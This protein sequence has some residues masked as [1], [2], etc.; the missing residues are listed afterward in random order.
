MNSIIKRLGYSDRYDRADKRYAL[1]FPDE[2]HFIQSAE[3]NEIQSVQD[4]KLKRVAGYILQDGRKVSGGDPIVEAVTG[5]VTKFRLRLPVASIYI[6]GLV[7]DVPE[8]NYVLPASGDVSVGVRITETMQDSVSNPELRAQLVKFQE[9]YWEPGA[10]RVRFDVAWGHSLDEVAGPLLPVYSIRNGAI[11]TN[12]TNIDYS[13]IYN[14]I[15]DYSRESNG[16]FVNSGCTVSALGL[17]AA[18]EQQ[19]TIS[20]GVAYVNGRRIPRNQNFR[21][22]VKEEPDLRAISAEPHPFTQP[23]GG[24]QTFTLAKSP[25][26]EVTRV[27][28]EKEVTETVIHGPFTGAADALVHP[29]VTA[30]LEVKKDATVYTSPASWLLSQGKL[31]WSPGGPEPAPGTTYTVKYRYNDNVTPDLVTRDTVTVTGAANG[32]NVQFDYTYKMPRIDIIAMDMTGNV[33]YVPGVAAIDRPQAPKASLGQLELARVYNKWGVAPDIVESAVR[34]IEYAEIT[35]MRGA[36]LDLYDLVAQERLKADISSRDVAAKRGVFVDPFIDDDL[37]DQGIAQTAASFGGALRLPI[38]ARVHEFPAMT[39]V[40][41]LEF[42]DEVVL[43]QFRETGE[44]KIN[45]YATFTPMPGRAS[46]EPSVD[47]WTEKETLFP[48]N[49]TAQFQPPARGPNGNNTTITS[50]S[51]DAKVEKIRETTRAAEFVRQRDVNFRLEGFIEAETLTKVLFDGVAATVTG[52]GPANSDG[53]ITGVL[54]IPAS[55]PQGS[56]RVAFVGSVGTEASSTYVAN[57]SITTE[58]YRLATAL[59]GTTEELPDPVINVTN[60]TNNTNITVVNQSTVVNNVTNIN[61]VANTTI[62]NSGSR[63]NGSAGGR[64]DPLAQTFMLTEGRCI[65]AVRLKCKTKGASSNAIFVQIRTVE[66][67]LPTRTILAEAFVPGSDLAVG[68]WFT[69]RLSVPVYLEPGREYAFVAL[70]DDNTHSLAIAELGKIDQQNSIVSEQ[71]FVVGV[72]LSSSNSLTWTVHNDADLAFQVIACRFNPTE[73]TIPIGTFTA[74][75]MSDIIVN[76]GVETPESQASVEIILR[77]LNKPDIVASPG[78]RIQ[79]TEYI[80]NEAVQVLALLKGTSRLTPFLFPGLQV[81]EGEIKTT[82]DYVS[83]AMQA[84]DADRVTTTI[85]VFVPSGASLVVEIG[86]PGDWVASAPIK[87]TP[88]GDGVFE[89]TYQRKPYAPLDARTRI[90]LNGGPAARLEIAKLRTISTDI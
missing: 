33:L 83:R 36:L 35:N 63:G 22:T 75:K 40:Q 1:A 71:P 76:A 27:I 34:N 84:D 60:V 89:Q 86:V 50:V 67:G 43:S 61:Q 2:A 51:L 9:S 81:V 45:P 38:S 37:R 32:T 64:S 66:V 23:T 47:I 79:L 39:T 78:Q 12:E 41:M 62:P 4:D 16:S 30:I 21:F 55:I 57:G 77:R 31:D 58:E 53:V 3:L 8:K 74:T 59:N 18:L 10:S 85:D 25:I 20:E 70:T 6:A 56:K 5:D 26:A 24:T 28:I 82:G 17:N 72:L 80:I 19:F 65:S 46:L 48:S 54:A 7:H 11:L 14:A 88:L 29:S 44:M 73:R 87:S 49:T 15:A 90:T 68:A 42:T 69:A 52:A 13:A